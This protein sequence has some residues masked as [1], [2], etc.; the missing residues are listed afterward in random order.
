M[1]H[2][3]YSLLVEDSRSA[4]ELAQQAFLINGY[5][6]HIE[7]KCD[8]KEALDFLFQRNGPAEDLVAGPPS[9]ILLDLKMPKVG[10][11][12]VLEQIRSDPNL[13]SALVVILTASA[14]RHDVK[15]AYDSGANSYLVKPVDFEEFV[16]MIG[17]VVDYWCKLNE[18]PAVFEPA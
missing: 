12:E 4:I 5:S 17:Q 14:G 18:L 2:S 6:G 13:K 15:Q 10:G 1:A 8:G 9:L 11:L 7:V 3:P 16:A